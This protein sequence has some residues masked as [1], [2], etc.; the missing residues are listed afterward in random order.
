MPLCLTRRPAQRS[1]PQARPVQRGPRGRS[2][3]GSHI[4]NGLLP[5]LGS[6]GEEQ[7]QEK[8]YKKETKKEGWCLDEEEGALVAENTVY[9]AF[10]A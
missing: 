4:S 3:P 7:S 8:R 9:I 6:E 5:A 1:A 10:R 2:S